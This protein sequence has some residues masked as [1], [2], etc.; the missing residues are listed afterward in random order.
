MLTSPKA[1]E[2]LRPRLPRTK[3]VSAARALRAITEWYFGTVYGRWEG[4]GIMPFYCDP[5]RVGHFAVDSRALAAGDAA[6]LFRLFV[7]MSMFQARP[8]VRI[9]A[10]QRSMSRADANSLGSAAVLA[11]RVRAQSCTCFS[12]ARTFDSDCSVFKTST[13]VDCEHQPTMGCHVK[14]ASILLR[15]TGD[16]GKLPT[17]AWLHLWPAMGSGSL[18]ADAVTRSSDPRERAFLVVRRL[19]SVYRVGEKL[20][21]MY[22]SS[23]ATPALGQGVTPWFPVLDGAALVVVDTNVARAVDHFTAGR[24]TTYGARARWLYAAAKQVDLRAM[25]SDI[26]SFSPRLVQQALYSFCSRSNRVSRGDSCSPCCP[27]P[28]LCPICNC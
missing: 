16:M 26:P 24:R 19:A 15:R 1:I 27:A 25:R 4:A 14:T 20:A 10:Q 2:Q 28:L 13:G 7:T 12:D 11:S 21:T 9:M 8:D 5:A 17:S 18:L 23:L 6:A 3:S 22:V